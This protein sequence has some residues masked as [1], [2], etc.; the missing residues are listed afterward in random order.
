MKDIFNS[1]RENSFNPQIIYD[2]NTE[3]P[4]EFSSIDLT[5]FTNYKKNYD[6]VS[7]L[8]EDYYKEKIIFL[9]SNK[10]PKIF[11]NYSK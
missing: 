7:E 5:Q 8:I 6:F 4:I 3:A 2:P 1:I 9:E 11:K 10:S